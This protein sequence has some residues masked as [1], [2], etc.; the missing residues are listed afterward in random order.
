MACMRTFALLLVGACGLMTGQQSVPVDEL[1]RQFK[2]SESFWEQFEVGEKLAKSHDHSVIEQL[3]PYL[4]AQDRHVRGNAAFVIAA[5]GDDRGFEVIADILKDRSTRP[6]GQGSPGGNWSVA[7]QVKNDRYY[8]VH[9]LGDLKDARAVPILIPLLHDPEVNWIVPWSLGQTGDEAAVPPLI[10]TLDDASPNMRVLA[11]YALEALK[12][13]Q[14]L[15]RLRLMV[16][17]QERI[18]FDGLGTVAD[19]AKKAVSELQALP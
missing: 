15:P 7:V 12:A 2:T 17:D 8:A 1:L 6:E 5:L 3:E 11:I 13:K 4:K 9:L 18:N 10:D 19:A 14:S 16:N